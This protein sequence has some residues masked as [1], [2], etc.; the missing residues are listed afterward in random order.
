MAGW[1]TLRGIT[2]CPAPCCEGF[3]EATLNL[4]LL[5]RPTVCQE[6]PSLGMESL[7]TSPET[8]DLKTLHQE[9]DQ[10]QKSRISFQ[11]SS[12]QSVQKIEDIHLL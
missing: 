10:T 6:K 8:N 7:H 12:K 1:K 9:I 3:E 11:P 2:L 5:Q 4:P